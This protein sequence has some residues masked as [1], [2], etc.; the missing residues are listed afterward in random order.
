MSEMTRFGADLIQALSEALADA[1][2]ENVPG[3]KLHDVPLTP[4]THD[5]EALSTGRSSK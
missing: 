5:L 2:G 4:S 1:Q 3:M